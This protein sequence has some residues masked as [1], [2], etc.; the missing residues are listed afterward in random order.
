LKEVGALLLTIS[1]PT[2]TSSGGKKANA[3][4]KFKV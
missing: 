1:K 2:V 4:H 3:W